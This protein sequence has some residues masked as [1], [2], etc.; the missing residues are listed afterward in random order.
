[1]PKSK[2]DAG[3]SS[4]SAKPSKPSDDLMGLPVEPTGLEGAAFQSR[5]P[6]DKMTQVEAACFPDLVSPQQSQKL[7]VGIRNQLLQ[8]PI[9]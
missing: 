1:V 8:G 3:T 9:L 5:V 2:P 4:E 7:F 6:F